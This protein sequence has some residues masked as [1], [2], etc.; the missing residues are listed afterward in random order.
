MKKNISVFLGIL[1]GALLFAEKPIV[2]NINAVGGKGKNISVFWMLPENSE[3]T[4]FLIYRNTKIISDYSQIEH[5]T[6]IATV[7]SSTNSYNDSVSDFVEYF[8]AVI[9]VTTEPYQII[10]PSVNSTTEGASLQKQKAKKIEKAI[11]EEK[12]FME[13]TSRDTP[14][15][16]LNI[17]EEKNQS[18]ISKKALKNVSTLKG[19]SKKENVDLTPYFFEEDLVSPDGGD[20]FLLF[21]ILKTTFAPKNYEAAITE[22]NKLIGTNISE[23]TQNRA[24]FYLGQSLYMIGKFEDAIKTFVIVQ[25]VYPNLSKKWIDSALDKI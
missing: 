23:D 17:L 24:T 18:A 14:L 7:S 8:Y 25:T 4:E 20:D 2:K 3:I 11:K 10:I 21:Q 16:Y 5:L 22:L 6:P 13:G 1:M 15:P 19:K 12:L 9:A